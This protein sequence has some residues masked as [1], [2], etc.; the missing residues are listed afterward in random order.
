MNVIKIS[1]RGYC[2]GV[3]DALKIAIHASKNKELPQPIYILGN[4]IH[5]HFVSD[6]LSHQGIKTVDEKGTSRIELLDLIDKGTV[7][8]TAHGVS[9]LVHDKAKEK[10]LHV[11]DATC[12]DVTKTHDY[13][14]QQINQGYDIIYIGKKHHPEPEGA[15]GI[16]P[17]H[18]HLIE[19]VEDIETL[20]I[21]NEQIAV[22]NQTTMSLW[23]IYKIFE[24]LKEHY[25]GAEFMQEICDATQVRQEAVAI[26]AKLAD[27][28]IVVGDP[29]SN[30]TNKLVDVSIKKAG[31]PAYRVKNVEDIKPDWLKDCKTVAVSSGASTP[32]AIT[33]EVITY[34]E[35]FDYEN[36]ETWDIETECNVTNILPRFRT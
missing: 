4:I 31:T 36:K 33:K 8:F 35:Q 21:T 28:T 3:V 22:T 1:P 18:V 25:P 14:R 6:A 15:V 2:Y 11:I 27:V 34:L 29:K 16:S 20:S 26:Q 12:K 9:P 17:E 30:N 19:T 10:G 23:D 13:I 7:I 32:T 24:K 5:N